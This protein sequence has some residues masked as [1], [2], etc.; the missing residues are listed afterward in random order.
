MGIV[1]SYVCFPEYR[2]CF[3]SVKWEDVSIRKWEVNVVQSR[4]QVFGVHVVLSRAICLRY[5][6]DAAVLGTRYGRRTIWN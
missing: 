2:Y 4:C 5:H 1:G 6:C 3:V